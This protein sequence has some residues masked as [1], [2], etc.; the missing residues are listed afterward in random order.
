MPE[1][2]RANTKGSTYF[3]TVN[4]YQRRPVLA[5]EPVRVALREAIAL[6]RATHPFQIEAWVLLPDH[7]HCIWTL[8]PDDA[9]FSVRWAMIKQH[10]SKRCHAYAAPHGE[11]SAS[12]RNRKE[13]GLWQRRFWEHQIRD[14][15]D[16]ARHVDYIHWN[17]VKHGYVRRA[18]DWPHS[19]FHRF[20][21]RGAYAKD[22]GG[23]LIC[24]NVDGSFGE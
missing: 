6:T 8:P 2:R 1:Y 14:E 7:L 11:L 24:E 21:E 16:F 19:T 18:A 17:P 15:E 23:H 20:V 10:V 9:S 13:V 5:K 3:F 22:W 4:A 12:R